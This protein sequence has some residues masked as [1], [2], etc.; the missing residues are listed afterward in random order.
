MKKRILFLLSM[1]FFMT[2]VLS[3]KEDPERFS[4]ED[5]ELAMSKTGLEEYNEIKDRLLKDFDIN[6]AIEVATRNGRV[7][8]DMLHTIMT[9]FFFDLRGESP[10]RDIIPVLEAYIAM[11]NESLL[12]GSSDS[13]LK[14]KC[15]TFHRSVMELLGNDMVLSSVD[16]ASVAEMINSLDEDT[17]RLLVDQAQ[18]LLIYLKKRF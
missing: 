12:D 13:S 18:K 3:G 8:E 2:F 1:A 4:K 16:D 5:E 7:D 17:R 15:S 6:A 10:L 11:M 9:N 14:A